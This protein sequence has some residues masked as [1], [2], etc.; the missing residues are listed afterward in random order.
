MLIGAILANTSGNR[1]EIRRALGAVERPLYFVLLIFA[2][3]AWVPSTR[4]WVIPV[5][6]FVAVRSAAKVGGAYLG[7]RLNQSLP[8]LGWG[9][10]RALLGQGGLAVALAL[11]YFQQDGAPLANIVFTAAVVSV[12][13]TDVASARLAES[14]VGSAKRRHAERYVAAGSGQEG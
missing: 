14:V 10:G 6:V 7:A 4:A 3:A 2:G 8:A 12:I 1:E 13:L 11:N 5:I 9:W